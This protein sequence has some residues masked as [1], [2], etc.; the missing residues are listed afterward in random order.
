MND[1]SCLLDFKR[2]DDYFF[3]LDEKDVR[4]LRMVLHEVSM[5]RY[6]CRNSVDMTIAVLQQRIGQYASI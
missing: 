2:N 5:R 4:D 1:N 6:S 3:T